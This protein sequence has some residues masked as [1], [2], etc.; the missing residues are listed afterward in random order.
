MAESDFEGQREGEKVIMVF[1]RHILTTQRGSILAWFCAGVD[2]E[3][4]R[5]NDFCLDG[6]CI[7]GTAGLGLCL[8]IMVF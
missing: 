4:C 6:V 8:C 3:G 2:M 5:S 1:R 7:T